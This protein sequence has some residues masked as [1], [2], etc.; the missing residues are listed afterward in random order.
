MMMTGTK[1]QDTRQADINEYGE[2]GEQQGEIQYEEASAIQ[3]GVI[4]GEVF[5]YKVGK[6]DLVQ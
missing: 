5:K 3:Q 2:K 1:R 6:E 4:E